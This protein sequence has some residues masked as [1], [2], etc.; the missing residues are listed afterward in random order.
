MP[1]DAL[2]TIWR[3]F[4]GYCPTCGEGRL[5]KAFLKVNDHCPACG[6]ELHHHRADDF[7]AYLVIVI[8][9]H[10]VVPMALSA[11]TAF[12]PAYWVHWLLWLPLTLGLTLGLI[13]PVKGAVVAMQWYLGM[14]GFEL[15]KK[16]R[17]LAAA[18]NPAAS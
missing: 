7:P 10:I 12:H 13:Q 2:Q 4:R 9:G 1:R 14:H 8:V 17:V 18:R 3:G 16:A 5:F 15:A 11:E 6:E